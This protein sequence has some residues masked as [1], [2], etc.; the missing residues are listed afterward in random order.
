MRNRMT[1][2]EAIAWAAENGVTIEFRNYRHRKGESIAGTDLADIMYLS[3]GVRI[4]EAELW[5]DAGVVI[6]IA[7]DAMQRC[8]EGDEKANS[9][10]G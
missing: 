10:T 4:V 8:L 7:V 1:E 9:A 6:S 5:P 2:G 3:K